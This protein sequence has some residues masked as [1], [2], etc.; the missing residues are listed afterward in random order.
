[1]DPI[2]SEIINDPVIR[3]QY[4]A[5]LA[6]DTPYG[7]RG[8]W[9]PSAAWD[10]VRDLIH[11]KTAA[12]SREEFNRWLTE[13]DQEVLAPLV[14]WAV[15]VVGFP[16]DFHFDTPPPVDPSL[17]SEHWRVWDEWTDVTPE[18]ALDLILEE[19]GWAR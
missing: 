13:H 18:E 17:I 12:Q 3:A 11:G 19:G 1:M 4:E 2:E 14:K 9:T 16:F 5:A 6:S 10:E 15:E 7:A 8:D